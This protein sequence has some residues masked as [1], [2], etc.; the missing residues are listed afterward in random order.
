[1]MSATIAADDSHYYAAAYDIALIYAE[2]AICYASHTGAD[3]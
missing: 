3:D 2:R 1:M